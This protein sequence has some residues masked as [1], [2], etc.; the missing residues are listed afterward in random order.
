MNKKKLTILCV[1]TFLLVALLATA[2][3]LKLKHD[4]DVEAQRIY[5]ETYLVMDGVEYL[6]ASTQLDLSGKQITELEKLTELTALK[7]LNL[8]DTGISTEQYEL[9]RT[10]LPACEILWSVPFQGGHC[11]DTVQ[12]LT[13]EHLSEADLAAFA[14]LPNLTTVHAEGCRDYDAIFALIE[15]Y[16]ELEVACTV[17]IGGTDYPHTQDQLTVTDPDVAELKAQLPLLRKLE[18]VT[19]EGDLPSTEALVE[20]KEAFPN[21]TFLWEFT[22]CGVKTNTVAEFLNLSKHKMSDTSELEAAL[23]CFYD[24]EKVDMISCGISDEEMAALNRRHPDTRFV[25]TVNVAGAKLRTDTREFMPYKY[26]IKKVGSLYNL[27]YCTDLEV[28]DLGHKGVKDFS[29]LEYL[30]N[31][32]YLLLLECEV[33]DLS[34]IGNC[35]SLEMLELASTPIDDFWPLT[36]LTNLRDLNLSYTPFYYSARK[37]GK[38]G[39]LTPLY[40]MTWLDRLWLAN[41]RV[42]EENREK[43]REELPNTELLFFS[44]S[45][46]NFGWRYAPSYY[47]MRDILSMFYQYS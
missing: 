6:R 41:S 47:E 17:T 38:F 45:A 9:L 13:V 24:L 44:T 4:R 7:Q 10:A 22:V 25:W 42:G 8:R 3:I 29:Y 26:G 36:N 23:P 11:D 31:I 33:T 27:R 32:R 43:L 1:V 34:I 15:Q 14:Y 37:W 46:T 35:T 39:D 28:L 21:I 20:L 12:E 5:N 2:V 30:P 16:P 18:N 40:Q 19:L